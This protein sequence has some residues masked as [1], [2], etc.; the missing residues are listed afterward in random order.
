MTQRRGS[1]RGGQAGRSG[2]EVRR[3]FYGLS[4]RGRAE[5]SGLME[6][7]VSGRMS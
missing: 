5:G 1:G 6:E 3:Q 7:D 2:E 4:L